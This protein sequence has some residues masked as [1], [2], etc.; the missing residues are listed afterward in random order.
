MLKNPSQNQNNQTRMELIQMIL[1][2]EEYV[3]NNAQLR[4]AYNQNGSKFKKSLTAYFRGKSGITLPEKYNQM[5]S[6]NKAK[7]KA[8][9]R[10]A[11]ATYF[12]ATNELQSDPS[13]NFT[14]SFRPKKTN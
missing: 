13:N 7:L 4:Q 8:L 14:Q 12:R 3:L 9:L 11:F 6:Q 2:L 5:S 10:R 1:A